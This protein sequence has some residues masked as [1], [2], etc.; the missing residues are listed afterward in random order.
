METLGI[1]S[2]VMV[3]IQ[4]LVLLKPAVLPLRASREESQYRSLA[5]VGRPVEQVLHLDSVL[6]VPLP[7]P[8]ALSP[9]ASQR[10]C[11]CRSLACAGKQAELELHLDPS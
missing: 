4:V 6:A 10:E 1:V 2:P 5:C 11:Q 9:G 3:L 8:S 7:K